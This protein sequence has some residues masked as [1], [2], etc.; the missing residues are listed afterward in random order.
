MKG[1]RNALKRFSGKLVRDLAPGEDG[2]AISIEFP[3]LLRIATDEMDFLAFG[4]TAP[5]DGATEQPGRT[6]HQ[7]HH[8]RYIPRF[9]AVDREGAKLVLF[10]NFLN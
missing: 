6:R 1:G 2:G 8:Q 7:N 3:Q 10:R 5:C 4:Q 9:R